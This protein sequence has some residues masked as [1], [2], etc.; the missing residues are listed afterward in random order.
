MQNI[1]V[2][3]WTIRLSPFRK[4]FCKIFS[5]MLSSSLFSGRRSADLPCPSLFL[6]RVAKRHARV[7]CLVSVPVCT[8]CTPGPSDSFSMYTRHAA[9]IA[10]NIP[11]PLHNYHSR[12]ISE[13]VSNR[14]LLVVERLT[15]SQLYDISPTCS[16]KM[17]ASPASTLSHEAQFPHFPI[18]VSLKAMIECKSSFHLRRQ[19]APSY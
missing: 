16:G 9:L 1:S 5:D 12:I 3:S 6:V 18:N 11:R 13:N 2:Y 14:L 4:V 10:R 8:P 7:S 19:K 17:F 15:W